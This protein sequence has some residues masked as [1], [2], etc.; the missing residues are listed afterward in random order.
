MDADQAVETL[1]RVDPGFR[2]ICESL[3]PGLEP[4]EVADRVYGVSKGNP[5]MS[6]VNASSDG[7]RNG[8]G[9]TKGRG[10][11]RIDTDVKSTRFVN[12]AEKKPS[13]TA[14]KIG[15]GTTAVGAGISAVSLPKH[16]KE[17]PSAMKAAK[18]GPSVGEGV[19]SAVGAVRSLS[20][21]AQATLPG[22]ES[23]NA[24]KTGGKAVRAGVNVARENPRISAGLLL[25]AA[26]LHTANLGGEAIA[27]H[28]LHSTKTPKV[29]QPKLQGNVGKAWDEAQALI[30]KACNDGLI[31]KAEGLALGKAVWTDLSKADY[32]DSGNLT[33]GN[34]KLQTL[35]APPPVKVDTPKIQGKTSTTSSAPTKGGKSKSV[36]KSDERALD[37]TGEISKL[38]EDKQ[39]CFGWCSV[40]KIDG[41]DVIDKQNDM[42]E[43]D[44]IEKSAYDYMLNSRKGGDMHRRAAD[45]GVHHTADVIESFVLTPE[46]IEKMGLP[47]STPHGWWIGMQVHDDNLWADVKSGK[48]TK[49]SIHGT[50]QRTEVLVDD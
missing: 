35:K 28:V 49:F 3:F 21:P 4:R 10:R 46:K 13:S 25:G 15:L 43:I 50:G 14:H 34:I 5:D 7:W 18:T 27:T 26:A 29:K 17:I 2:D 45:G 6:D 30:I 19:K 41:K 12:K 38:N 1:H 24:L 33:S 39:Q 20:K 42:I 48:K 47:E 31:S 22:M 44:E 36:H 11:R 23:G 16:L 8:R 9:H 37:I 40:V 32:G